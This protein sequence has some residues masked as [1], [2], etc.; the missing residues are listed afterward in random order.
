MLQEAAEFADLLEDAVGRNA[1][2][3]IESYMDTVNVLV[4][5]A[6]EGNEEAKETV[7]RI[8]EE[9]LEENVKKWECEGSIYYCWFLEA[10]EIYMEEEQ[11]TQRQD[12]KR[13]TYPDKWDYSN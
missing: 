3:K 1:P 12:E 10:V 8:F 2:N 5:S 4:E 6:Q 13:G 7:E 9:P 11:E